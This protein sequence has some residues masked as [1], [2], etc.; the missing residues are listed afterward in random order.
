MR[1]LVVQ[2]TALSMQH[3]MDAK[4]LWSADFLVFY[5]TLAPTSRPNKSLTVR[6]NDSN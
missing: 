1:A 5:M 2:R 3:L 4:S 6:K